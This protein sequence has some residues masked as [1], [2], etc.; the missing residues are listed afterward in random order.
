MT[1]LVNTPTSAP[2]AGS[3]QTSTSAWQNNAIPVQSGTFTASFDAT[4]NTAS[5]DGVVG[6]SAASADAYSDLAVSARFYTNGVIEALNGSAYAATSQIPYMA[7]VSYRFRFVVRISSHTYDV[8]VTPAGGTEQV[9]GMNFAFR[10]EQASVTSLNT[11]ALVAKT[12][13][14]DVCN[15]NISAEPTPTA[16][17]TTT[18]TA[19]PTSTTTPTAPPTSTPTA[20]HTN[21]PVPTALPTSTATPTP[22]SMPT[23]TS[24]TQPSASS[25]FSFTPVADTYVNQTSPDSAYG[26]SASVSIVG[27][28]TS[29]KQAFLRFSVTDLPAGA[30]VSSAKL[31]LVVT[32]DSTSGGL[33][34]RL[35][36]TTWAEGITWNTKPAIDG[37]QLASLGAV[38][39]GQVVEVVLPV[40][41][42]TGNG[43]Y[44]F[45]ITLPSSNTNTLGYASR[46]ATV[47]NHPQLIITT[48]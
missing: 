40:G 15:F 10:T 45:A 36:N 47:A 28:S 23:A 7:G 42:I 38:T 27:G 30:S 32:N 11:W 29:A 46:E 12:G 44:S 37:A 6:L 8:F 21:T 39:S 25:T 34:H 33:F 17:Q 2:I 20:T 22:T 5:M 4:P 18:P 26:G 24:T 35:T 43:S 48:Q 16:T 19:A 31:R 1:P 41:T 9:I 13:T 3:C 14:H